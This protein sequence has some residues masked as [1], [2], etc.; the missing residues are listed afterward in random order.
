MRSSVSV[1]SLGH[2]RHSDT[3]VSKPD[4]NDSLFSNSGDLEVGAKKLRREGKPCS[5]AC[6]SIN[7]EISFKTISICQIIAELNTRTANIISYTA[8]LSKALFHP[9]SSEWDFPKPQSLK[10]FK[11]QC[12]ILT[13]RL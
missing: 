13:N 1:F 10:V 9:T 4:V 11:M 6:N 8:N 12:E 3:F 7:K 2:G 5:M